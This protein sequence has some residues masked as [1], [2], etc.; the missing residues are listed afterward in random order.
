MPYKQKFIVHSSEG[1]ED[2]D[3]G[4]GTNTVT[5]L[6]PSSWFIPSAFSLCPHMVE[7]ARD[8]YETF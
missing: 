4:Q 8:L 5:F 6:K 1:W 7:G 3:P 2:P